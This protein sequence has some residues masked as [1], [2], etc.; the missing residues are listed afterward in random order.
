MLPKS[1]ATRRNPHTDIAGCIPCREMAARLAE[2]RA[3][4]A[5]LH[6]AMSRVG[7][8]LGEHGCDCE[9]EDGDGPSEPCFACRIEEAMRG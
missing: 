7:E 5:A 3:E 6:A 2:S 9:I 1:E 8:L 4:C